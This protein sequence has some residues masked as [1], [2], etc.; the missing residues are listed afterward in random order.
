MAKTVFL[1][2]SCYVFFEFQLFF[3]KLPHALLYRTLRYE[4]VNVDRILLTHSMT[5]IFSLLIVV[6]IEIYIVNNDG[7]CGRQINT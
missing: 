7:I 6:G 4:S 3:V 2:V 5:S 1:T